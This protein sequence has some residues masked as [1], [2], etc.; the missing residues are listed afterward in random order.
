MPLEAI[1]GILGTYALSKVADAALSKA[2]PTTRRLFSEKIVPWWK[3][4]LA[5]NYLSLKGGQL[6][7]FYRNEKLIEIAL[8]DQSFVL[9]ATMVL[10]SISD[11]QLSKQNFD[12][13]WSTHPFE[14]SE[15]ID[16]YTTPVRSRIEKAKRFFDGRVVRLAGVRDAAETT[17]ISLCPA[18]YFDA[19]CTNFAMDHRPEGRTESLRELLHGNGH[20]LE[21]FG[22]SHLVD[23]I[24]VVCMVESADGMLVFQN[25][26]RA[27]ANRPG[28]VSS[29]VSGAANMT[30]IAA[31]REGATVTLTD[32]ARAM[33][34]E[35]LGELSVEPESIRFL[36]L[37]RELLRGGKPELYFYALSSLTLNQIIQSHRHAEERKE[38]K[39]IDGFEFHSSLVG[40]DDTSRFAFQRRVIDTISKY[41]N[42][43]NFTFVTGTLLTTAHVLRTTG[44]A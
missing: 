43:A 4:S 10:E 24:G 23:H 13:V 33:F 12:C 26:S 39:S 3:W 2:A 17:I 6:Q 16:A 34:R 30:D 37:I 5:E 41:V 31:V 38:S 36:G 1:L 8:G 14:I 44:R 25:R 7:N 22:E 28:T 18:S 15:Q 32:L 42:S 21:P 29:S 9:P 11:G 27:V 40:T 19:L 20:A 35:A